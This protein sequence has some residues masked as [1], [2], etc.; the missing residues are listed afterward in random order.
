MS[1][2][3]ANSLT[4]W[5]T[6]LLWAVWNLHRYSTNRRCPSKVVPL[7]LRA[8]CN[9]CPVTP[10]STTSREI[11]MYDMMRLHFHWPHMVS[12]VYKLLCQCS[13]CTQNG[14][15]VIH[16]LKLQLFLRARP[17]EFMEIDRLGLL[18]KAR[19]GIQ[20]G[21]IVTNLFSK[22]KNAIPTAKINSMQVGTIFLNNC[23]MPY[24][25]LSYVLADHGP[26]FVRKCFSSLCLFLGGE[27]SQEQ[28]TAAR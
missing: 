23:V 18:L 11:L 7:T 1:S 17:L 14:Y 21:F 22:L 10:H 16:K 26:Q 27:S 25:S 24:G 5:P 9:T 6:L 15:Q 28:L 12:D 8:A 4:P 2:F 20:Q 19:N 13:S 3:R